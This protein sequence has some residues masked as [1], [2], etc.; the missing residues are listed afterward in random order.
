MREMWEHHS[1]ER[2]YF[3]FLERWNSMLAICKWFLWYRKLWVV[4][5]DCLDDWI[6]KFSIQ[7]KFS[8]PLWE[9][10]IYK[11][12][13]WRLEFYKRNW[14]D[15]SQC[16]LIFQNSIYGYIDGKTN[17]YWLLRKWSYHPLQKFSRFK[18]KPFIFTNF[19]DDFSEEFAITLD[20]LLTRF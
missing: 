1:T 7:Q 12:G 5:P 13:S 19:D 3:E 9:I 11:N 16:T 4:G 17:Q 14:N 2:K 8:L 18:V 10:S 15:Y 6:E 20:T